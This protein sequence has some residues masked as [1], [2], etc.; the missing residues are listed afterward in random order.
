MKKMLAA[1]AIQLCLAFSIYSQTAP[2]SQAQKI[3][4]ANENVFKL[5][6]QGRNREA[7]PLA[8][9]NIPL[10]E[11]ILGKEHLETA[12]AYK[13][14]GYVYYGLS[15]Q[16]EAADAFEKAIEILKK[17]SNLSREDG[18]GWAEMLE[19][20]GF[21]KAAIAEYGSAERLYEQALDVREKFNGIDTA[22]S[23]AALAS[24]AKL[25][26]WKGNYAKSADY[27]QRLLKIKAKETG[28]KTDENLLILYRSECAFVKAGKKKQFEEFEKTLF[29][30][31]PDGAPSGSG[32]VIN[33]KAI[34]LAKPAYP[35]EAKKDNASGQAQVRVVIGENG[36]VLNACTVNKIHPA[37]ALAAEISAFQSEFEPTT[38]NGK[39]IRLTG[40]ITYNFVR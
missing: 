6:L 26:Y 17:V 23:V 7:L 28:F 36:K 31:A 37:L 13:N 21:F 34:Y 40:I 39:R 38:V 9:Q 12:K 14:L 16:K 18:N 24:V 35:V 27:Y 33:G 15:N 5:S 2:S 29:P 25:A 8:Q 10:A 22:E 3:I 4:E 32:K 1:L 30:A 11:Q 20:L 19:A